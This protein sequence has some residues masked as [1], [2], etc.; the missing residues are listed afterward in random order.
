MNQE[1]VRRMHEMYDSIETEYKPDLR[2]WLAEGL[3]TDETLK[4]NV[5]QIAKAGFGATEFLAMP[6]PGADSSVYGWGSEEW[7]SDTR[8]IV[9]EDTKRGLGFSLTSGAHW[10]T[11]NLPDTYVWKG[12]PYNPDAKAASK[13]LDYATILLAPGERF[14]GVLP[15]P[16]KKEGVSGDMHGNLATYTKYEFEGLVAAKIIKVRPECGQDFNYQEGTGTGVLDFDSLT[17]LSATVKEEDGV[18]T[19]T[20]TAPADGTYALFVYW[21]HGTGQTASPSVSTNYTINYM[22]KYGIEALIDYWE[23]EVL[24]DSLKQTIRKNGR[25]EI[26]MDSLELLSYGAGGIFWGYHLKEEFLKR[27]G[28]D[29][30]KYLPVIT[31]DTARVTAEKMKEYDYTIEKEGGARILRKLRQ[32][33]YEVMSKMYVENVLTPLSDWLHSLNMTLRAEPSYGTNFEISTPAVAIDGIETETYAMTA[34]VDLYRGL[35]GS[36][37]MYGRK[38]SSETGAVRGKNYCY[39]MDTWTALCFLQFAEGVNRTVFHGYSAIEGSEE[40]THWPGHEGM[41]ARYSERFNNRQPASIHYPEWTTMLGR[42]QKAL[43]QGSA[44]RDLAILRTDYFYVNYGKPKEHVDFEHGYMMYDKMYFWRDLSLQRN[45]YTYDY[46]SP[47]LLEDTKNVRCDGKLLMPDGVGY[48]A[49]VLYQD[50]LELSAAKAILKLAQSGLPVIFV[51]HTSEIISHDGYELK[52]E[53]AAAYSKGLSDS[54]EALK[55]VVDAIKALPAS[56]EISSQAELPALLK[57][58]GICA[59]VG[60]EKEN[61]SILTASRFDCENKVFYTFCFGYNFEVR[62]NDPPTTFTMVFEEAGV[63]YLLD[64]WNGEVKPLSY[65]VKDG[66]T[67]VTLTLQ[68]GDGMLLALDLS[69][70]AEGAQYP[71][72]KTGKVITLDRFDIEIEDWNEGEKVLNL[73]EKFGHITRE[74]YYTTKKTTLNFKNRKPV[75]WK[76]LEAGEELKKLAGA[77]PKMQ[78]VS[79]V[80]RYETTFTVPEDFEGGVLRLENAGGGTVKV[81]LNGEQ[82]GFVPTRRL[83]LPVEGK[84]RKGENT[85]RLEVT[86]TL[87]NRLIEKDFNSRNAKW[88]EEDLVA[89]AYGITGAVTIT[90]G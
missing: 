23:E 75:A 12:E 27:K 86:G 2:W 40:D 35:S 32:D 45:G 49:L 47:Q 14:T 82:A 90:E 70:P 8:L 39:S 48:K 18:L 59:R 85:I 22:D 83:T 7:T 58:M 88:T 10:A 50:D 41:Y 68:N 77:D 72:K 53:K 71:Q 15:Y 80:A 89:R 79:G 43:R 51:N 76:D 9:E 73:E 34:E 26:Y 37:N 33:F 78:D 57:E 20:Y 17:D 61:G 62:K 21:M 63:P 56:R 46:F 65:E 1:F 19:A 67:C 36:A 13:E 52:Y 28:Y 5:E 66:K 64:T 69:E 25:G 55:E 16:A 81:W 84:L 31:M 60:F 38:F 87:A 11:A 30:T 3:N 54:D 42:N 74:V 6:E 4:K 44:V 29:I 24:T